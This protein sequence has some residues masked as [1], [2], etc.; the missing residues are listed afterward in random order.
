MATDRQVERGPARGARPRA[1][2]LP[3]V[4]ERPSATAPPRSSCAGKKSFVMFHDD[5][6]GDGILGIWCAAPPGAQAELIETEPERFYRPA[7]VGHRG[8]I[9]V[10]LDVAPDWA[11]LRGIVADAYR[12]VAPKTLVAQLDDA[13]DRRRFGPSRRRAE[14]HRAM[15]V[16]STDGVELELHDLGGDG[17]ALLI[18]HATG[19]CAGAYLPMVPL[20]AERFHVWGIDFRAHG[21]STVPAE[22]LVAG[23]GRRRAG[24]GRRLGGGPVAGFGHSMGG[25]CLVGA[26]LARPG[27]LARA[28]LFEPIIIPAAWNDEGPGSEPHGRRRPPPPRRVRVPRRGARPLRPPASARRVPGRRPGGLRRPRVR[29][30]ARRRRHPQVHARARG[31]DLRGVEQAHHRVGRRGAHARSWWPAASATAS[32]ARPRSPG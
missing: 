7:Y 16:P 17:P 1:S 31:P 5:H 9:G 10:R 14:H 28:F 27:T 26:E 19:F 12:Q 22:P 21:D 8:W 20:L 25:A 15:R 6:H 29:R 24:R 4:T 3:E 11:E 18:A 32:S 13:A 23:H 2:A 30:R